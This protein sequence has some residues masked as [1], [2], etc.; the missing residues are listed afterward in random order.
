[1]AV[2]SFQENPNRRVATAAEL[3]AALSDGGLTVI[4]GAYHSPQLT[5]RAEW[6]AAVE[7]HMHRV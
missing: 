3:A 1:M 7:A 4:P 5:H 2:L 6:T